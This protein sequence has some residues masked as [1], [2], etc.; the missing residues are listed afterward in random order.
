MAQERKFIPLL[1]F[2]ITVLCSCCSKTTTEG[3]KAELLIK[4]G[5]MEIHTYVVACED[6]KS[7]RGY[8]PENVEYL[9]SQSQGGKGTN[10]YLWTR[11]ERDPWETKFKFDFTT[12]RIAIM[13]AGPDRRWNTADDLK[14][15]RPL[16]AGT[17]NK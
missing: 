16:P 10:F 5:Q 6:F 15:E 9:F 8:F 11:I 13:S 12:N 7:D 2:S 3:K 4:R 17:T 14:E 1:F